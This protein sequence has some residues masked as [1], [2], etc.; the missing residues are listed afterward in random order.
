MVLAA[1][2]G[3]FL[4]MCIGGAIVVIRSDRKRTTRSATDTAR[5]GRPLPM[6][7]P[8]EVFVDP[9]AATRI[10]RTA[11]Q[12]VGGHDITI[13]D[14]GSAIGWIGSALTNI[15]SKAEYM[16]AVS[17]MIQP[18]GSIVLGCSSQP[19]Y[20]TMAFGNRRSADLTQRLVSEVT[21]LASNPTG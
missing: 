10:A 5:Q 13:L 21:N 14:D 16:I 1:F 7:T 18:D 17:R 12:L 2:V 15:P 8:V 19:R 9:D 3:V 6:G 4:A 11:I 20:S